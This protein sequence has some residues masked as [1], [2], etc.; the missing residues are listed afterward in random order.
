M[1]QRRPVRVFVALSAALALAGCSG[2]VPAAEPDAPV[3]A[4]DPALRALLPD[5]VRS[6][7]RLLVGTDPSYPPAS[8]YAAD[9]RTIVGFEPDLGA[10]LGELLGVEVEFRD[11]SFDTLLDETGADRLDAVMSA[12]TWTPERQELADFVTYFEAG[13]SIVVQRGNPHAVHDLQGLC[14]RRVAVEQGTIQVDLLERISAAHCAS[15]PILVTPAGTND[16]ALLELRTGRA[17]AVL[18]DYPPADHVTTAE[19]TRASYQLVPDVQYEPGLYG[20]AVSPDRP[21]L[22]DALAAALARLVESGRYAE[23][24]ADW[25]VTSGAVDAVTVNGVHHAG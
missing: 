10:A 25:D 2:A 15:T 14:G 13:T 18:A 1:I 5:D 21:E 7:G 8:S 11:T 24:L 23:V 9:G 16:D 4:V 3:L 22:R 20:V 19:Q 17:A 6:A 12:M